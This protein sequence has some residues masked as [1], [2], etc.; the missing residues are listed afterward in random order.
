MSGYKGLRSIKGKK[1][2]L[3]ALG[4]VLKSENRGKTAVNETAAG[5]CLSPAL[6]SPGLKK[7][8]P[9]SGCFSENN[10]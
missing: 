2:D 7:E 3:F 5:I 6:I 8:T 9:F 10:P 1:V 4:V